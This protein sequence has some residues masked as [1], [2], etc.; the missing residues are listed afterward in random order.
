MRIIY[1]NNFD[2]YVSYPSRDVSLKTD[3]LII[4]Y[5][6][7]RYSALV[8]PLYYNFTKFYKEYYL[9]M[10]HNMILLIYIF[11]LS[12]LTSISE[13]VIYSNNYI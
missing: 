6:F 1:V 4:L 13:E 12:I 7:P 3:Y 5:I 9:F 10:T 11:K 8:L 2:A